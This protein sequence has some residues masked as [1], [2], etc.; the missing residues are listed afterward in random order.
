ML[1]RST[2]LTLDIGF[3]HVTNFDQE[4]KIE[5]MMSRPGLGLK[6]I[7]FCFSASAITIRTCL[8]TSLRRRMRNMGAVMSAE[9]HLDQRAAE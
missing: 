2:S 6:N 3:G 4:N 1:A 9:P 7:Y 8:A 5:M